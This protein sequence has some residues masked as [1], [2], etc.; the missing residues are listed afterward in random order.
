[1]LDKEVAGDHGVADERR[2][3]QESG[4]DG[5]ERGNKRFPVHLSQNCPV[6]TTVAMDIGSQP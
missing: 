4:A 6:W 5:L 3:Q 2:G 1:M